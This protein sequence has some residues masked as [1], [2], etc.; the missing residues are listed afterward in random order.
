MKRGVIKNLYTWTK[1][2]CSKDG[3]LED[4]FKTIVKDFANNGYSKKYI[5]KMINGKK[6]RK[7]KHDKK[8]ERGHY[9]TIH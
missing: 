4:E 8:N 3:Y 7:T 1:N 9:H 2:V 6:N 5:Y